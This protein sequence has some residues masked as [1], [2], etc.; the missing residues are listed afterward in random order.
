MLLNVGNWVTHRC[1]DNLTS[2]L[3][4]GSSIIQK[5]R[6][7]WILLSK[8][9]KEQ[10]QYR[11]WRE[12]YARKLKN[13]WIKSLRET[14]SQAILQGH[15]DKILVAP[16]EWTGCQVMSPVLPV[17]HPHY[18][19]RPPDAH[20]H[21][22]GKSSVSEKR[23]TLGWHDSY[24]I[25]PAFLFFFNIDCLCVT[26]SRED[27]WT[28]IKYCI[29]NSDKVCSGGNNRVSRASWWHDDLQSLFLSFSDSLWS[30]ALC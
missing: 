15:G 2:S 10:I 18:L 30:P 13:Q 12:N 8:S 21:S 22:R 9:E 24:I 5:C 3:A 1:D 16:Q 26:D 6:L 29:S 28:K 20:G 7:E 11:V 4:L 14:F 25:V 27:W 17:R 19:D 23:S